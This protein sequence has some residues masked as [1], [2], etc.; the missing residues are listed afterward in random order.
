M[1]VVFRPMGIQKADVV[2]RNETFQNNQIAQ[3][4]QRI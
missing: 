4:P 1:G 2:V 3:N